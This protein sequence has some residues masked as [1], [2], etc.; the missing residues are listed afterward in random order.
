[1]VRILLKFLQKAETWT[2]LQSYVLKCGYTF[3]H[4]LNTIEGIL[5]PDS[6]SSCIKLTSS[7]LTPYHFTIF[8][9]VEMFLEGT[10]VPQP[11]VTV[12]SMPTMCRIENFF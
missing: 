4:T 2:I 9:T 3:Q 5:V 11:N 1:M 6:D 12:F 8:L 7:A 10:S